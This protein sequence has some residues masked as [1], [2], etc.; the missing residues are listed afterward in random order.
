MC[1]INKLKDHLHQ[2]FE[3]NDLGPIQRHLEV[4][5]DQDSSDLCMHQIQYAFNILHLFNMEQCAPSYIPLPKGMFLYILCAPTLSRDKTTPCI[6]VTL[7][8]MS[9]G[10]LFFLLKHDYISPMLSMLLVD[11]C[12]TPK[13]L[14]CKLQNTF[15]AICFDI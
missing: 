8:R 4:Q 5:F 15:Y 9:I 6:D 2:N 1:L 10:K 7:H 11:S 14:T 13:G 3:I 12:N